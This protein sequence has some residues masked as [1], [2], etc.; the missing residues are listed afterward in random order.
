MAEITTR[1]RMAEQG[2]YSYSVI[3]L[4]TFS[5]DKPSE[6]PAKKKMYRKD[7]RK[8]WSYILLSLS[9]LQHGTMIQ[10]TIGKLRS[11]NQ[12]ITLIAS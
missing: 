9:F 4:K 6:P 2:E 8:F 7:K 3:S 10:L 12:S 1:V 11:L 5:L